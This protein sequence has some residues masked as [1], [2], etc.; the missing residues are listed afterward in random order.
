MSV[1]RDAARALYKAAFAAA[2][3]AGFELSREPVRLVPQEKLVEIV[4]RSQ[5]LALEGEGGE[6]G[7][8][9]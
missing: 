8:E 6:V 1:E 5:R 9:P 3:D 4:R 7:E 2:R